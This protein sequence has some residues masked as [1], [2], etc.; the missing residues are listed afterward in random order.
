MLERIWF[1]AVEA[2][3]DFLSAEDVE[4][5][6][7]RL[8]SDYLPVVDL[9]VAELGGT[10]IA[11]AGVAD[12]RLEMLFVDAA[13]RGCGAGSALLLDAMN[14][15]PGLLVDVNEQNPQAVGFY[16]HHGLVQIG[17]SSTDGDGRPYPL[18]HLAAPV[19][20]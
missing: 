16:R 7:S 5:Y 14:R 9:T 18:L 15:I 20:T 11:F 6:R 1:S 4:H 19:R 8:V 12:D 10:V 3:H 17:R 2:T 13:H